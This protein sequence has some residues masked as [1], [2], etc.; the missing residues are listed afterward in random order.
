MMNRHARSIARRRL[1]LAAAGLAVTGPA[2]AHTPYRQWVVYR[3]RHLLI[4][5]DRQ[6]PAGYALAKR[7][8][9]MLDEALPAAKPRVARAPHADRL[10]SLLA[11]NQIA[12]ALLMP[13]EAEALHRGTA[14]FGH[15]GTNPLAVLWR[16]D[17]FVLV[18]RAD[19]PAEHAALL[20]ETFDHHTTDW[21][22]S[23]E[24]TAVGPV[25]VH[26]GIGDRG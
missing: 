8:E 9:V 5:C 26:R 12:V 7:L 15:Y 14:P 10:A 2:A 4:G 21:N 20:V 18:S 11:T 17:P 1:L 3:Q 6:K 22:G 24:P 13:E 19:F 16:F 25:P 23:A